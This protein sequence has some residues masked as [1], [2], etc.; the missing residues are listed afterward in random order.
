MR[1]SLTMINIQRNLI[2]LPPFFHLPIMLPPNLH[3]R[4]LFPMIQI[5]L[6]I[7][8]RHSHLSTYR[9]CVTGQVRY[10]ML[11]NGRSGFLIILTFNHPEPSVSGSH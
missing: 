3:N 2:I 4:I 6:P 10:P 11:W 8:P 7:P 1:L 5:T 9:P